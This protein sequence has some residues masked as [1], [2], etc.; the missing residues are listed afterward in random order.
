MDK[1]LDSKRKFKSLIAGVKRINETPNSLL[2]STS[3]K[4]ADKLASTKGVVNKSI[5]DFT[6]KLKGRTENMK[7]VFGD[8]LETVDGFLGSVK[9]DPV[10]PKKK[11]LIKSKTLEYAKKSAQIAM[12]ASKNVIVDEV[13]NNFFSGQGT[14]DP[15]TTIPESSYTLSPKSFD[16]TNM[17]KVN[18][19]STSGKLMYEALQNPETGMRFNTKLYNKFDDP[20]I[21]TIYKK[22]GTTLFDIEW[23]PSTQLYTISG[24]G[25][26]MKIN[27]FIS[28]YYDTIEQPN[29]GN[30]MTSAMLMTLQGDGTEGSSFNVG[31][32]LLE[33]LST[34]LCSICGNSSNDNSPFLNNA[35]EQF[36]EDEVDVQDYFNFD[37]VEGIDLDDEDARNRRVLKFTDCNNFEIPTN[38]NHIEDFA[39]LLGS[40]NIDENIKNTLNKVASDAYEQSDNSIHMDGFQLSIM[41][42][43]ILK[44]PRAII[45]NV[46]SPKVIF[47]IALVFQMLSDEIISIVE[48]MKRM[49]TMFFKM[50][51]KLFWRFIKE[52]W[53][54]IKKDL[55]VFVATTAAVIL[56]NKV[57]RHRGI[58]L[59]LIA[60]LLKVLKLGIKSCAD[61]FNALLQTLKSALNKKVK[62][63]IPGLLLVLSE[64]LPGFSSD[65]AFM[66]A[67]EKMEAS[68]I[69]TGPI[70][71]SENKLPSVIKG[72]I[73][74]YSSEVDDNSYIKI[75]L[76]P[77]VIPA[78]PGSAIIS[79]LV[80]GT[81][82]M[83]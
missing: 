45:S 13:K 76:N 63:P 20:S 67:L 8:L 15:N 2:Q 81:G 35:A 28:D 58:I 44:M 74:G 41:S 27:N 36:N 26:G 48:L 57:K 69:N 16:L 29:I 18:P 5:N 43:L 25:S 31:S 72:I 33:R 39:Y 62:I 70:Y 66:G 12:D 30:V 47:P 82:K 68:G 11:P 51:T 60:I 79:P 40:K 78:G 23:N 32:N 7:D 52:F 42:S 24:M 75:A 4:Y 77:A 3:D 21:E 14:C 34:K 50:I 38:S 56:L 22:D 80:T 54:F 19:T 65:R 59:A 46:L 83:F 55:L 37:D 1:G 17:L 53:G 10:N 6:S 49:A 73:D 71:G 61:M 64:R 9:E